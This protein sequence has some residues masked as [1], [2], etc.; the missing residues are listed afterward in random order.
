MLDAKFFRA[1]FDPQMRADLHLQSGEVFEIGAVHAVEDGYVV[2]QVYPPEE[3]DAAAKRARGEPLPKDASGATDRLV[4][5][6]ES[7]ACVHLAPAA[8]HTGRAAGF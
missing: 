3:T 6:Y 8:R 7:I 5:S 4:V 1:A 2:L